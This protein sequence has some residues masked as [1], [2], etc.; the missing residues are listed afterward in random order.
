M[1]ALCGEAGSPGKH[2][3]R[4]VS[5]GDRIVDFGHSGCEAQQAAQR[6]PNS[7]HGELLREVALQRFEKEA[8]D[9]DAAAVHYLVRGSL[10]QSRA[11]TSTPS[12]QG[13]LAIPQYFESA[14]RLV[15]S[16]ITVFRLPYPRPVR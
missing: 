2:R 11:G 3:A 7:L 9:A 15:R 13:R 4:P 12:R 1:S 6:A 8:S 5:G 14:M 10:A 16:S